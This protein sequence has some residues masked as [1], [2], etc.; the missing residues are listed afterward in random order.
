M[1]EPPIVLR[2]KIYQSKFTETA[3]TYRGTYGDAD[4][5]IKLRK[6]LM[7]REVRVLRSLDDP[8]FPKVLAYDEVEDGYRLVLELL[9]GIRIAEYIGADAEIKSRRMDETESTEILR[10]LSLGMI[11]LRDTGYYY[12]DLNMN[13]I[14]IDRSD[15]VRVSLIDHEADVHIGPNGKAAVESRMGTWESMSPE[16]FEVGNEMTE[17]SVTYGLGTLLYQ[18][19]HGE[20]AFRVAVDPPEG[21]TSRELS[22]SYHAE[23]I[24]AEK[25]EHMREILIKA[26]DPD[27]AKRF[28]TIEEFMAALPGA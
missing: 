10:Q 24:A 22:Q 18:L 23:P 20:A 26:L 28:A 13:H 3:G 25:V 9:P 7:G 12:R 1:G 15:G 21:M 2:D 14:L 17:A 11:A 16:E 6:D 27:P 8:R 4:A 19:T 5:V